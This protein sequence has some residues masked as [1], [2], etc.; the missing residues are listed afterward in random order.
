MGLRDF[1]NEP[2]TT[3]IREIN[4][5]TVKIVEIKDELKEKE[6]EEKKLLSEDQANK[7]QE[8][9][10]DIFKACELEK[11]DIWNFIHD[12]REIGEKEDPREFTKEMGKVAR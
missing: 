2:I 5:D 9:C 3:L 11:N 4:D 10:D 8:H 1:F 6:F 12:T 7:I